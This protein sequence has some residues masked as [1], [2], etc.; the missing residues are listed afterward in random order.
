MLSRITIKGRLYAVA[1]LVAVL[2]LGMIGFILFR[3]SEILAA[4]AVQGSFR[5]LAYKCGHAAGNLA[6]MRK[7]TTDLRLAVGTP[8]KLAD[9]YKAWTAQNQDF[10]KTTAD[11]LKIATEADKGDLQSV[12]E[13]AAQYAKAVEANYEAIQ[14]GAL[15]NDDEARNRFENARDRVKVLVERMDKKADIY[16]A[17]ATQ[18]ALSNEKSVELIVRSVIAI[19]LATVII[20]VGLT[21]MIARSILRPLSQITERVEDV[22]RGN[23]DLTRRVGMATSDELGRL[24]Q[25]LDQFLDTTTE[26]VRDVAQNVK[27]TFE[28]AG[29]LSEASRSLS[30]GTDRMSQK[31]GSIAAAATQLNQ[32]L[33][34]VSSSIEEMS[35]SVGDIATRSVEAANVAAEANSRTE[36]AA[37]IVGS[38]GQS[39]KEIGKVIESIV[40]IA[41]QT[42]LLALNAA[43]EAADAGDTGKRFAVVAAEV[44]EL[45]RQTG[46]SSE[47][48]RTRI[49]TMRGS[50]AETVR[51]IETISGVIQ[52][53]NEV[54]GAIASFV[55]E[56]SIASR[57]VS[58]NAVSAATVS[59]T[60]AENAHGISGAVSDGATQ[61][62]R[63]SAMADKLI[64]MARQ[65]QVSIDR[66]KT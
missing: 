60:V 10:K 44:K 34:V 38:L 15:K 19:A 28:T 65:L 63:I 43:I 58:R 50:V 57:E 6:N 39:A 47:E 11:M 21:L 32:N 66:F 8:T 52:K 22:A 62:T 40:D 55:E 4:N 56:Q 30:A 48:I 13:E 49:E 18:A 2:L 26:I 31:A 36:A 64:T 53:V 29:D 27:V 24:A 16:D 51:A 61:A 20:G 35:I 17:A 42:N 54:N 59:T 33:E 7:L 41:D 45:A 5:N 9:N 3:G 12:I 23:G 25:A 1:A 14:S 46:D 37:D